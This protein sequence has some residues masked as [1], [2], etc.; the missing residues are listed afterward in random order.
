MRCKGLA[1]KGSPAVACG[2]LPAIFVAFW[3]HS[4]VSPVACAT[5]QFKTWVLHD[6]HKAYFFRCDACLLQHRLPPVAWAMPFS[7]SKVFLIGR[8]TVFFIL[9]AAFQPMWTEPRSLA[10][11][12]LTRLFPFFSCRLSRM[13]VIISRGSCRCAST[14]MPSGYLPMVAAAVIS[15]FIGGMLP[16][17]SFDSRVYVSCDLYA[18]VGGCLHGNSGTSATRLSK[19]TDELQP[20]VVRVDNWSL[21]FS[22]CFC[23]FIP[24]HAAVRQEV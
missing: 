10:P 22:C 7:L 21:F 8:F 20:V 3:A 16:R 4:V 19:Q 5:I 18:E 13:Y 23:L 11:F 1:A 17:S 12:T 6:M 24:R 2:A 14:T 15:F 9:F